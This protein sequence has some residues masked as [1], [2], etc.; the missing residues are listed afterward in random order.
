MVIAAFDALLVMV[1]LALKDATALGAN[2]MLIEVLCPA[3]TVSGRLV[4]AREKYWLEIA[5]LLMV[6]VAAPEFVTIAERVSL[7]PAATLPKFRVDV[8]KESVP[9][10]CWPAEPPM[11]KPWQPASKVSAAKRSTASAT[12]AG[13]FEEIGIAAGFRI[14]SRRPVAPSFYDRSA[15]RG[16]L[17]QVWRSGRDCSRCPRCITPTVGRSVSN[18]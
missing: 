13:R 17:P 11:L 12:F 9:D 7:L 6:T 14:V 10:C 16:R 3:A 1:A 8:D 2:E 4:G 5:M 18:L 15:P